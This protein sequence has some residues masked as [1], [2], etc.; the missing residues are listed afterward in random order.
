M[1]DYGTVATLPLA[2]GT[3]S[4]CYTYYNHYSSPRRPAIIE[5]SQAHLRSAPPEICSTIASIIGIEVEELIELNPSLER[6]NCVME[7]GFSY[8]A[9]ETR[10]GSTHKPHRTKPSTDEPEGTRAPDPPI[11]HFDPKKGDA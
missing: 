9:E 1:S 10:S 6:G 11:C 8:C 2:P 4:T 3:A 7:P 5:A